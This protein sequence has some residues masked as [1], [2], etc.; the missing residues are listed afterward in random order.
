MCL[1]TC[2]WVYTHMSVHMHRDQKRASDPLE[3]ELQVAVSCPVWVKDLKTEQQALLMAELSLKPPFTILTSWSTLNILSFF[4]IFS[5]KS[6]DPFEMRWFTIV[7]KLSALK[8][9]FIYTVC[10]SIA[11]CEAG[12][13]A[14]GGSPLNSWAVSPVPLIAYVLLKTSRNFLLLTV[15]AT[16]YL[17]TQSV[18]W[19]LVH[20]RNPASD[21]YLEGSRV[22]FQKRV[23]RSGLCHRRHLST[24]PPHQHENNQEL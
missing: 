9:P 23:H 13:S 20:K 11:T 6:W 12:S 22:R 19:L 2:V 17:L 16:S 1:C 3:P 5:F 21:L 7:L 4:F 18:S 15:P 8:S 24:G 14:R 10:L